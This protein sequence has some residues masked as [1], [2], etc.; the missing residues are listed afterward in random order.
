MWK[1]LQCYYFP[2]IRILMIV[3]QR[4]QR[5]VLPD[6]PEVKKFF[7]NVAYL[8]RSSDAQRKGYLCMD[9]GILVERILHTSCWISSTLGCMIVMS[10][11]S[12]AERFPYL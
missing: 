9:L 10:N 6:W 11:G 7:L 5:L 12:N 1:G 2:A 8:S 3:M 4:I